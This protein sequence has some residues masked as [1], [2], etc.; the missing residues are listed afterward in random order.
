M[1]KSGKPRRH[2]TQIHDGDWITPH[3]RDYRLACCDCGLTHDVQ[4]RIVRGSVQFRASRN[5]RATSAARRA[6][7]IVIPVL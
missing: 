6:K 7:R 2:Y 5:N 4:F 1:S 3:H